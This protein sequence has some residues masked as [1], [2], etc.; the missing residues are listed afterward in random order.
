[1]MTSGKS[2]TVN[3]DN[4]FALSM[5]WTSTYAELTSTIKGTIGSMFNNLNAM[6]GFV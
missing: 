5:S 6:T 3:I 1:M 2:I 4:A